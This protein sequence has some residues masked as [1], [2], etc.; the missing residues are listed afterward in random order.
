MLLVQSMKI[1]KIRSCSRNA[2][3]QFE[4]CTALSDGIHG[5]VYKKLCSAVFNFQQICVNPSSH[6]LA[7]HIRVI[8]CHSVYSLME[9]LMTKAPGCYRYYYLEWY[10]AK[11][12]KA[13]GRLEAPYW[14]GPP[15]PTWN[16]T[17]DMAVRLGWAEKKKAGVNVFGTTRML[18]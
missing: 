18:P 8:S 1:W 6:Y 13:G 12:L 2:C 15:V 17:L 4:G 10:Y 14:D 3:D 9:D 11:F 16:E 7:P 5:V